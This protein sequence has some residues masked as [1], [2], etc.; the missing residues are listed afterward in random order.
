MPTKIIRKTR[1]LYFIPV[2]ILAACGVILP[3][4]VLEVDE[5]PKLHSY[6]YASDDEQSFYRLSWDYYG[7]NVSFEQYNLDGTRQQVT[8][9]PDF[10][11]SSPYY[12]V[13]PVG[14]N[15]AF[16]ADRTL[17]EIAFFD[18][19]N[20]D[21][22][23]GVDLDFLAPDESLVNRSGYLVNNS[24]ELV[25]AGGIYKPSDDLEDRIFVAAIARINRQGKV[26]P[27]EYPDSNR[28][29]LYRIKHKDQFLLVGR[30]SDEY[31]QRTG[32]AS[33]IQHLDED[34][35]VLW[36][37]E[38]DVE[39]QAEHVA[40]ERFY[41]RTTHADGRSVTAVFDLK[42]QLVREADFEF[43]L[44]DKY[45]WG[46]DVLYTLDS[47]ASDSFVYGWVFEVCQYS[48]EFE[49]NWCRLTDKS[50]DI[51]LENAQLVN[52]DQFALTYETEDLKVLDATID[53]DKLD[54]AYLAAFDVQGQIRYQVH[55]EIY[56]KNGKKVFDADE[57]AFSTF[58][59]MSICVYL[60]P[61]I[62]EEESAAPGIIASTGSLFLSG[63]RVISTSFYAE[64]AFGEWFP[65]MSLFES[66]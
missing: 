53:I 14:N 17:S 11:S 24:G 13:H 59:P 33:F 21:Y 55:H 2:L 40:K 28:I 35:N 7:K 38:F 41:G 6:M 48:Y 56:A 4:W 65:R 64:K 49:K 15:A 30:Y 37:G 23:I 5:P 52:D 26:F 25:F 45:L 57:D 51:Q 8:N 31:L 66:P 50:D 36:S 54:A 20:S 22:W 39:V 16:F 61:C 9:L 43:L 3:T 46:E 34:F 58:G 27:I 44:R 63:Q 10:T 29:D 19:E 62:E 1:L 42:G 47:K 60:Q 32:K 18:P 12:K